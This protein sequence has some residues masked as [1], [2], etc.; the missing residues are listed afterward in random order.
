MAN[1]MDTIK[2]ELAKSGIAEA[3][4]VNVKFKNGETFQLVSDN[5]PA[6]KRE[7]TDENPVEVTFGQSAKAGR[8]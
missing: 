6:L 2:A 1:L 5:H 4:S 8:V 3:V 7:V